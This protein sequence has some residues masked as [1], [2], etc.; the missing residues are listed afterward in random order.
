MSDKERE[1]GIRSKYFNRSVETKSQLQPAS[2]SQIKLATSGS[3]RIGAAQQT[4]ANE[5]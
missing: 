4:P 3:K 2:L 1:T 5:R